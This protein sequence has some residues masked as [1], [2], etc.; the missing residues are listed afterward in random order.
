M[1]DIEQNPAGCVSWDVAQL[2]TGQLD[3]ERNLVAFDEAWIGG[4]SV[5]RSAL[6]QVRTAA[7]WSAVVLPA[8]ESGA[9]YFE[10]RRLVSGD[11]VLVPP[12]RSLE[13]LTHSVARVYLMAFRG[14]AGSRV[15]LR[16]PHW[17]VRAD[18]HAVSGFAEDLNLLMARA[19][20][21]DSHAAAALQM[22]WITWLR[23][24]MVDAERADD[25]APALPRRRM[26]V[27]RVRRFIHEH[28]SETMTL[29]ELCRH[30]HL[31]A[32]SLEYGFR[33]LVGL[34]PF[35]YI[36]MLRLGE[37]RRRLQASSPAER[38]VSEVAL[39]CGFCHLSQF[40]ADYKRVFLESP[41]ATRRAAGCARP[42]RVARYVTGPVALAAR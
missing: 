33:D 23:A 8:P 37:V 24:A 38:S 18:G 19:G 7:G 2:A 10:G 42:A 26:A 3:V 25:D 9:V 32:R 4:V 1:R 40:A 17:Y 29:A 21:G 28:L 15:R 20:S 14:G 36:K 39:D 35:K 16:R 30:A 13:L 27:E 34:S 12:D 31:Q 6:H 22:R 41:S 5:D 11:A